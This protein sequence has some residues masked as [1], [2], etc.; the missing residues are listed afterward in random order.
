MCVC[1]CGTFRY[2]QPDVAMYFWNKYGAACCIYAAVRKS[3][4]W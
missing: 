2:F 4:L 3:C 1:V